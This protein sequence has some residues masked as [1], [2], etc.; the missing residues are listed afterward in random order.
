MPG[1]FRCATDKESADALFHELTLG[2]NVA[3]AEDE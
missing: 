2:G 3:F 1:G